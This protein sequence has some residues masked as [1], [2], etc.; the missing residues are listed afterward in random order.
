MGA[1]YDGM[2][3]RD[4]MYWEGHTTRMLRSDPGKPSESGPGQ[5]RQP[6][7]ETAAPDA[8]PAIRCAQCGLT[9]ARPS[10]R[11]AIQG[12]HRHTFANPAGI[13]Y[14]IVCLHPVVGCGYIGP[15]TDEFSWFAG[16]RWRIAV[17]GRCGI[18]LGWRFSSGGGHVFHGLI[19]DRL[20]G[21]DAP[22]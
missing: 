6:T 20:A 9:V 13:V 11:I 17:C 10:A 3:E 19:L 2:K 7:P 1:T 14:E 16:Y 15:E 22:D 21:S 18:Q 4:T 12:A 5:E 8:E